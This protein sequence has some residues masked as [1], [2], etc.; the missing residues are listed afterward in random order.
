MSLKPMS[1]K[2]QSGQVIV[3]VAVGLIAMIGMAGMV[4][5]GGRAYADERSTEAAAEAAAHAGAFLLEKNWD[6]A[7]GSFGALTNAQVIASA[8]AYANYNGFDATNGDIF[9]LDYVKADRITH[10]ATLDNTAR[11]VLVQISK[12][13]T[14]TFSRVLGFRLYS[15]FAR[16]TAMFGSAMVAGALPLAV[17]DSCFSAYNVSI[18]WQPANGS[19]NFG[20]CNF[21]SIVPPGCA[22][23][24]LACYN[25]ALA[26]GMNPPVTLGPTYPV[27]S[28]DCCT[29]SA[30]SVAQLQGRINARPGETC[31]T[32]KN[33]SPRVFF[34][35]VVPGGFGGATVTFTRYRAFF[36]TS[37]EPSSPS[38]G[39]TGC[40]VKA[41]VNG[42]NFDPNAV[43]TAYGGVMI[44][45]LV[46][47][48]GTIVPIT[49]TL[50]SLTNP[51]LR[52]A[53]N[54]TTLTIHT[55]QVGATCTVL[56]FDI[57]PAP[58]SPSVA[59]GLGPKVTDAAMNATW[60]WT[61]EPTALTGIVQLQV[62][63]SYH[64][65]EGYLF[66]ST[67]VA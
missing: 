26:N 46:R 13:Q 38:K 30:T 22:S 27:N 36:L 18:G 28:F 64:G 15:V 40:F 58:G 53:V 37:I 6:G 11:G 3:I 57:P 10:V 44:M 49:I 23:G 55:D 19:G 9:Y 5:D 50:T 60:T 4:I 47:S 63:C 8:Q 39:F 7:A 24:N 62:T 41:T 51:A 17:D 16:A 14:A 65:L 43:G 56:F 21:A 2:S 52:G 31:T 54:G 12:P 48:T 35:P 1:R 34:V 33:P 29:L 42:G 61:V 59:G 20:T 66:T 45:K 32:F 25:N 67:V